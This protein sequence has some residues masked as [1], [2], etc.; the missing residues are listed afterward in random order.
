MGLVMNFKIELEREDDGRWIAEI[1]D[2]PGVLVYRMS[3]DDAMGH[4]Q[5]LASCV[6]VDRAEHGDG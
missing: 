2:L 5:T 6:L 4:L 3:Q 1:P